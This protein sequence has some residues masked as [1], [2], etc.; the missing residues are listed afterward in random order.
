MD[1]VYIGCDD[2]YRHGSKVQFNNIAS[3]PNDLKVKVIV[4]DLFW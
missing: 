1:M 3:L 4:L 2:R